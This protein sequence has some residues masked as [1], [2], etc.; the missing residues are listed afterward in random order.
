VPAHTSNTTNPLVESLRQAIAIDERRRLFRIYRWADPKAYKP[1]RF[2]PAEAPPQDIKQ[3]WFAGYHSDIGGGFAENESGIAKYPLKW[4]IDEAVRHGLHV[5]RAVQGGIII[6]D[7]A[8]EKSQE[9]EV[10][11]VGPGARDESPERQPLLAI[12]R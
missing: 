6:P 12:F 2:D 1:N 8:K 11:A 4:M 10:V 3:V 5:N 9:G 7:T